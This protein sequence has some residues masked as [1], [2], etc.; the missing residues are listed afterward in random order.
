MQTLLES[1]S[2][3]TAISFYGGSRQIYLCTHAPSQVEGPHL[4]CLR[5]CLN[6]IP[7][8]RPD[9]TSGVASLGTALDFMLCSVVHGSRA[10]NG[11]KTSSSGTGGLCARGLLLLS[12]AAAQEAALAPSSHQTGPAALPV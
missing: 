5:S 12:L 11:G 6:H 8:T 7:R 3:I 10:V 2:G 1:V 9:C 4:S